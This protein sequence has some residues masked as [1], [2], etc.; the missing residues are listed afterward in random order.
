MMVTLFNKRHPLSIFTSGPITQNGPISTSSAISANG[1]TTACSEI[2]RS[3]EKKRSASNDEN[4]LGRL[5]PLGLGL[6]LALPFG[7]ELTTYVTSDTDRGRKTADTI[8]GLFT[9]TTQTG[10]ASTSMNLMSASAASLSATNA[11]QRTCPVRLF[12]RTASA[13]RIN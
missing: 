7:I 10:S 11:L 2:F 9:E 5:G 13:S 4:Q 12:T 1:S 8:G 3:V 6:V